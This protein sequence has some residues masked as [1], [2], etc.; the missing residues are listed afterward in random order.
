MRPNVTQRLLFT[1]ALLPL[2]HG[3]ALAGVEC[4]DTYLPA[5][6]LGFMRVLLILCA[7][8]WV[9]GVLAAWRSLVL[10]TFGRAALTALITAVPFAQV[11][12]FRPL[13][14]HS[15]CIVSIDDDI[16]QFAQH[17]FGAGAWVW[18]AIWV[19]WG[20]ERRAMNRR[21]D[22]AAGL[23]ARHPP[24]R[25]LT[26]TA[27]RLLA[28]IGHVPICFAVAIITQD[29]LDTFTTLANP[30]RSALAYGV[31]A[32]CSVLLMELV[33]RQEPASQARG[34]GVH[35]GLP[36][37]L[38]GVPIGI[39]ALW[40][41]QLGRPFDTLVGVGPVVGWGAWLGVAPIFWRLGPV[42]LEARGEGPKCLDCGY[43]LTGLCGTRCP[44]CGHEP[45]LDEL[46]RSKAV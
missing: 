2:V 5:Q 43:P 19:W 11:I 29:A 34:L 27:R 6:P 33:W 28:T 35:V 8:L 17:E 42:G 45:T 3:L 30:T 41:D 36:L 40:L 25:R 20:W 46:W 21:T 18:L 16:L 4:I 15:G 38:M 12:I 26:G 44:E 10:W 13:W 1:L 24:T 37:V 22:T 7:S 32:V 14:T 9:I 23:E 31:A 39:V